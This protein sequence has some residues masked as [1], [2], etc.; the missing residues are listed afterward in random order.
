MQ[1]LSDEQLKALEAE[2]YSPDAGEDPQPL[3]DQAPLESGAEPLESGEDGQSQRDAQQDD[4]SAQDGGDPRVALQEARQ[5]QREERAARRKYER[6]LEEMREHSQKLQEALQI[7]AA[8]REAWAAQQRGPAPQEDVIDP[9]GDAPDPLMDPDA[10]RDWARGQQQMLQEVHQAQ[11]Q[12]R[13]QRQEQARRQQMAQQ[14]DTVAQRHIADF[15]L[16][17]PSAEYQ[18]AETFLIDQRLREYT[19]AGYPEPY[20]RQEIAREWA[21]VIVQQERSGGNAAKWVYETAKM[22]GWRPGGQQGVAA[23]ASDPATT[24]AVRQ[25]QARQTRGTAGSNGAARRGGMTPKDVVSYSAADLATMSA[26]DLAKVYRAF[27]GQ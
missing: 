21:R 3:D 1:D 4:A 13:Q 9:M 27:E 19:S 24:L 12:E 22:R 15:A 25:Q 26:D 6:Q 5:K 7:Q 23:P 14:I 16:E 10:Y 17:V 18:Q 8:Q 20:A 2:G 11:Q